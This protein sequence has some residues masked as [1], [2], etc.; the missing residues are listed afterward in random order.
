[1]TESILLQNAFNNYYTKYKRLHIDVIRC[2]IEYELPTKP[3]TSYMVLQNP[4]PMFKIYTIIAIDFTGESVKSTPTNNKMII[5]DGTLHDG[6][7][8]VVYITSK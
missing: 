7:K 1:M 3:S 6:S 2:I 8:Y 5:R 4:D